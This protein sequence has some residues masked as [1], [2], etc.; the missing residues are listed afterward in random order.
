MNLRKFSFAINK[1]GYIGFINVLLGKLGL[2]FRLDTQLKKLIVWHGKEMERI[3]NKK[4]IDGNYKGVSFHINK[5]WNTTDSAS[6]YLGLYELEVQN[7]I[8]NNQK[9]KKL[10]RKYFINLGAGEGYHPIS[11]LKNKPTFSHVS[12]IINRFLGILCYNNSVNY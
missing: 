12:P 5:N 3:C 10:R 7:V 6:K 2:K 4:I 11:L 1:H 9:N 8:I